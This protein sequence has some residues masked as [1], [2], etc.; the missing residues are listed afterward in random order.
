MENRK[1]LINYKIWLENI[2][3][4]FAIFPYISFGIL[5]YDTQPY[6]FIAIIIYLAFIKKI[7]YRNL[8]YLW[9]FFLIL[10]IINAVNYISDLDFTLT[11]RAL[12]SYSI[13]FLVWIVSFHIH[14]N[15]NPLIHYLIGSWIYIS[16]GFLQSIG[17]KFLDWMSANR[18]TGNRG[19]NSFTVEPTYFGIMLFFLAW[20]TL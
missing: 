14:S 18:T 10:W 19:V 20:I 3:L 16:Y 15:R 12:I 5:P 7:F 8:F 6:V 9:S 1:Y 11:I 4:Y 13:F 2:V 17:I